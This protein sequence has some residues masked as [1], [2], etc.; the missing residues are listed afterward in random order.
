MKM[1]G[2]YR[3]IAQHQRYLSYASA[4]RQACDSVAPAAA[5][6]ALCVRRPAPRAA[7]PAPRAALAFGAWGQ[8]YI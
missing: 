7:R 8:G 3:W 6:G 1:R 2:D 5:F 4:V